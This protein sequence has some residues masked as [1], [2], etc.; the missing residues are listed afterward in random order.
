[1]SQPPE[2]TTTDLPSQGAA[3]PRGDGWRL[4]QVAPG[5]E[6]PDR[7]DKAARQKGMV[8]AILGGAAFWAAVAG[9]I[10]LVRSAN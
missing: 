2:V 4:A 10:V 9:V 7:P 5:P 8:I 6:T 3:E 1:M